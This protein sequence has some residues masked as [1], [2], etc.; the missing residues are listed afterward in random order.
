MA[1]ENKTNKRKKLTSDFMIEVDV[2]NGADIEAAKNGA[3]WFFERL[4][5]LNMT[6]KS[7]RLIHIKSHEEYIAGGFVEHFISLKNNYPLLTHTIENIH[8]TIFFFFKENT[9]Y[10]EF[11]IEVTDEIM[12]NIRDWEEYEY[13]EY[14][15]N[16]EGYR[17][18][19]DLDYLE[20]AITLIDACGGD[21]N[22]TF[23]CLIEKERQ[24]F[25]VKKLDF[26]MFAM[27]GYV[28]SLE[29]EHAELN[30]FLI[31]NAIFGLFLAEKANLHSENVANEA[32]NI[33]RS[34]LKNTAILRHKK[35]NESIQPRIDKAVAIW[36]AGNAAHNRG[37]KDFTECTTAIFN[38]P[39]IDKPYRTVY[40]WISKHEQ[41]KRTRQL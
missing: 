2:A 22:I 9:K 30:D 32:H 38:L 3:D 36:E 24:D 12:S 20:H 19:K 6:V 11:S 13:N 21:L 26:L 35:N 15:S 5:Y 29:T 7:G 10:L 23:D 34:R 4:A 1:T 17:A 8:K 40:G 16:F 27:L 28:N 18:A 31:I 37:W 33:L 39:E 14:A 41:A 25:R